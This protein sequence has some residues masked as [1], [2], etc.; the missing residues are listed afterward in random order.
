MMNRYIDIMIDE[1]I[2]FSRSILPN[3]KVR[4]GYSKGNVK[5]NSLTLVPAIIT[6][7][8][9]YDFY[10]K[11][12]VLLHELGHLF[13]ERIGKQNEYIP[14]ILAAAYLYREGMLPEDIINILSVLYPSKENLYRVILVYLTL[15]YLKRR[16]KD[17]IK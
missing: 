15:D 13:L 8:R 12:F 11:K 17:G 2:R 4:F 3:I 10:T 9:N 6:L 16:E 5:Y 14:D 7:N 1:Y